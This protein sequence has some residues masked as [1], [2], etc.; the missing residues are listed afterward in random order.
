MSWEELAMMEAEERPTPARRYIDLTLELRDLDPATER[1]TV[2]LTGSPVGE[3]IPEPASMN[4]AELEAGLAELEDGGIEEEEDLVA[5][6]RALADRLLPAGVVRTK[7]TELLRNLGPDD[8]VRLRLLI[9]EPRLA[10]LPWEYTYLSVL[11]RDSPMDFLALHP[12]VSMVR[13]EPLPYSHPSVT[14]RDPNRLR[15]IAGTANAPGYRELR[16][17]KERRVVQQALKDLPDDGASI[18][19]EPFLENPSVDAL[20]RAILTKADLFHFAGHGGF[21]PGRGFIVL[22]SPDGTTADHLPA[23]TLGKLLSGAGVRLAVLGACETGRRDGSSPWAGVAPA[24]VSENVPAVVAMQYK[25]LNQPAVKFAREFYRG[26]VVGLSVDEAVY[27]GRLAVHDP[28]DPS[29]SWGIPVLYHRSAD[30]VVFPHFHQRPSAT[31]DALRVRVRQV[32]DTIG[33]GGKVVG[34]KVVQGVGAVGSIHVI[35]DVGVVNGTLTGVE[36][37]GG[38]DAIRPRRPRVPDEAD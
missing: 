22:P 10:Q 18:D 23:D 25:I 6:G 38:P 17:D 7:V 3:P 30:G 29:A 1:Y 32:V 27:W 35:E 15:L 36:I 12:K 31:A 21:Q 26:L 2:S 8:G 20:R 34:V 37:G 4:H 24:L 11:G 33:K 14:P 28:D 5:F 9:W 16:L 13:H 19:Y